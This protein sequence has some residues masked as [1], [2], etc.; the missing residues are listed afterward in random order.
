[1]DNIR[2]LFKSDS[3][4]LFIF[5]AGFRKDIYRWTNSLGSN[6]EPYIIADAHMFSD[7]LQIVLYK[8]MGMKIQGL[9]KQYLENL[10]K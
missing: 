3:K 9:T 4:S 10:W 1:M 2:L 8:N 7:D 6:P 5:K